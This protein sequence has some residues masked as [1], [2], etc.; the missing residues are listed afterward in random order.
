MLIF[1]YASGANR[2]VK[3]QTLRELDQNT[4]RL[5]QVNFQTSKEYPF[6]E[7]PG[8][9]YKGGFQEVIQVA[10]EVYE[11]V[12][13]KQKAEEK[14][15]EEAAEKKHA[16][17]LAAHKRTGD[18]E[19]VERYNSDLIK[20]AEGAEKALKAELAVNAELVEQMKLLN[21]AYNAL[22]AA[23]VKGWLRRVFWQRGRG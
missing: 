13:A 18:V 22:T 19:A 15:K 3:G 11:A 10:D 5:G 23:G 20:R 17:I 9:A 6:G 2:I 1:S 4:A 16:E 8:I 7:C 21:D 12:I 14:A